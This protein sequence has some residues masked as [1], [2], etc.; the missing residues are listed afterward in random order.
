MNMS[1]Q[2][3]QQKEQIPET[4]SEVIRAENFQKHERL[5]SRFKKN[6]I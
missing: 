2:V 1:L 3:R 6:N 5:G 4:I